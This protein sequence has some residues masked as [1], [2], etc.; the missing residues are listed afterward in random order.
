M[1][2]SYLGA[3]CKTYEEISDNLTIEALALR[4]ACALAC[5]LA[6]ERGYNRV[7]FQG[8]IVRLSNLS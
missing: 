1:Y 6:A 8:M 2:V 3:T 4:D 5:A 7:I